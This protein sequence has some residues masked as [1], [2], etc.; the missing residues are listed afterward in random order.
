MTMRFPLGQITWSTFVRTR[1]TCK[2]LADESR[3]KLYR[4]EMNRLQNS[5]L[6]DSSTDHINFRIW[7]SHITDDGTILQFIQWFSR[8]G[9]LASWCSDDNIDLF[10]HFFE[11]NHLVTFHASQEIE[12]W[13]WSI[14]AERRF[15][16]LVKRIWDRFLSHRRNNP[17]RAGL[18]SILCPLHLEKEFIV[19]FGKHQRQS[20]RL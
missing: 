5:S 3:K 16:R 10:D 19:S 17:Y 20:N 13:W 1:S 8:D 4:N 11:T 15:T 18:N 12:E 2:S 9:I 7:M 14:I 6:H